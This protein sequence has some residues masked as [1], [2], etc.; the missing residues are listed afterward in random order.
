[1]LVLTR[2]KD[3]S[4]MIGEDVEVII[5]DISNKKVRL[6]ISAPRMIPVHRKEIYEAISLQEER[7]SEM[8]LMHS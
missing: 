2:E 7:S 8:I 1:M 5:V 4:I 3:E 6:G